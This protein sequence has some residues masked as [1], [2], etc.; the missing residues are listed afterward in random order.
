MGQP[1]CQLEWRYGQYG[2]RGGEVVPGEVVP[3]EVV[4]LYSLASFV[5]MEHLVIG[6]PT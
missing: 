1:V 6:I 2:V 3:G 5:A 4:P